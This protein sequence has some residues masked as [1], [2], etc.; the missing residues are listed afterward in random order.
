MPQKASLLIVDDNRDAAD[1]LGDALQALGYRVCVVHGAIEA[2]A[3]FDELRPDAA[4]LDIGLP[5]LDGYELA[6]KLLER[7]PNLCLIAITGYGQAHDRERAIA[8]GFAAHLVKPVSL[9]DLTA[10]ID[11]YCATQ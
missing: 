1:L 8:A 7:R 4:L 2:L 10:T 11:Q 6:R 5:V 9:P 3:A